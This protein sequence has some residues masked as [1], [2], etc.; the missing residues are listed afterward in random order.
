MWDGGFHDAP[1]DEREGQ[2]EDSDDGDMPWEPNPVTKPQPWEAQ[3]WG[4]TPEEK[5]FRDLMADDEDSKEG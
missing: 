1:E 4:G 5:M 3:Q 2:W